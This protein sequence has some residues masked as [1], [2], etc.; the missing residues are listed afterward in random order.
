[1]SALSPSNCSQSR[2][3]L[4]SRLLS[5]SSFRLRPQSATQRNSDAGY[6]TQ[7]RPAATR[8]RCGAL[9][10]WL[11]LAALLLGGVA[12]VAMFG[13]PNSTSLA[14]R[15]SVTFITTAVFFGIA[16]IGNIAG[17]GFGLAA[18]FR[19]NDRHWLG[20]AG[21]FCNILALLGAGG[22]F[23]VAGIPRYLTMI[24]AMG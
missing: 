10:L 21:V 2:L 16:P 19:R 5:L 11:A 14:L 24:V 22:I 3:S 20:A 7:T 13:F 15:V 6:E 9:S 18:L 12:L 23:V 17:L 4:R 1:M 8:G